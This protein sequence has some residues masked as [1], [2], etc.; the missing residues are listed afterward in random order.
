MSKLYPL[1]LRSLSGEPFVRLRVPGRVSDVPLEE[2]IRKHA[3][4]PHELSPFAN[5]PRRQAVLTCRDGRLKADF[6]RRK[7]PRA[8]PSDLLWT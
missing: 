7:K 5:P 1:K 2:F 3:G 6:L 8:A 4:D